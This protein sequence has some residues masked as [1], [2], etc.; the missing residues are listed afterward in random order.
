MAKH[1]EFPEDHIACG[2]LNA[3][4][5]VNYSQAQVTFS[6]LCRRCTDL[7]TAEAN[8]KRCTKISTVWLTVWL[9]LSSG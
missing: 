4:S 1:A 5:W 9:T 7:F 6:L 3:T 8:R 2:L